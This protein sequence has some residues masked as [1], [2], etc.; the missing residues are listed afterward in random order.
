MPQISE[1]QIRERAYHIWQ[2]SGCPSGN[3]LEHWLLAEN[4]MRLTGKAQRPAK[5]AI[6]QRK[7]ATGE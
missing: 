7:P 5:K 4:E 2:Q 3:E 1:D 6:T